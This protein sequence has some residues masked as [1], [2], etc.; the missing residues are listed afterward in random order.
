MLYMLGPAFGFLCLYKLSKVDEF[1]KTRSTWNLKNVEITIKKVAWIKY[2]I[3]FTAL[4][5]LNYCSF[6]TIFTAY[7]INK[8]VSKQIHKTRVR[9]I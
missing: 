3:I 8:G 7:F 4:N 2:P 5:P 9:I 6:S 1:D